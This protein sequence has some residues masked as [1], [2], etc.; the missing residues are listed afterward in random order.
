MVS[1]LCILCVYA[2]ALNTGGLERFKWARTKKNKQLKSNEMNTKKTLQYCNR[3]E[4]ICSFFSSSFLLANHW[5]AHVCFSMIH[6]SVLVAFL[7]IPLLFYLFFASHSVSICIQ[8]E[9]KQKKRHKQNKVN[10]SARLCE[11]H[12]NSQKKKSIA[13]ELD[14]SE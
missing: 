3:I 4:T 10:K 6:R 13:T 2:R 11:K 12:Y 7:L 1:V 9:K 14:Q 8:K 5:N